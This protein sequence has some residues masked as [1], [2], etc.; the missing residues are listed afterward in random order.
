MKKDNTMK[1]N[2]ITHILRNV[3]AYLFLYASFMTI[4][5]NSTFYLWVSTKPI[6]FFILIIFDILSVIIYGIINHIVI[7]KIVGL[8]TVVI[9]ET[10]LILLMVVLIF[11]NFRYENRL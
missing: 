6:G 3:C 11:C 8:K 1:E 9:F 10:I 2:N 7:K 5:Y 4:A